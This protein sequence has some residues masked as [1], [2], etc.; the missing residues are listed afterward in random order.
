MSCCSCGKVREELSNLVGVIRKKAPLFSEALFIR[1]VI[2][3]ALWLRLSALRTTCA[4]L[5]VPFCLEIKALAG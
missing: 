4:H 3:F 5:S 1:T 2:P